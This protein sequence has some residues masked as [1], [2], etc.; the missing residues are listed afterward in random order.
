M[1]VFVFT[2][3]AQR[4]IANSQGNIYSY[5]LAIILCSML[6][7]FIGATLFCKEYYED[8]RYIFP[9]LLFLAFFGSRFFKSSQSDNYIKEYSKLTTIYNNR[10]YKIVEGFVHVL[11]LEPEGGHDSGDIIQI[12]KVEF[13][14]SCF[15]DT[16]GYNK[17]IVY[18][19]VLTENTFAR[20]YYYPTDDLSSRG[21][22]ILRIDMTEQPTVPIKK[23]NPNNL[24][25]A[26]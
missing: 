6:V 23:I 9:A 24:C 22:I 3:K 25:A 17:S 20:V 4:L 18:G 14:I 8:R 5:S 16:L 2:D 19:G 21:N 13:E 12:N 7:I 10:E 26:Y 15:D 11:H 1:T